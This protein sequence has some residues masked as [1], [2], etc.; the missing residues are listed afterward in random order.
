MEDDAS[1]RD[2]PCENRFYLNYR[3]SWRLFQPMRVISCTPYSVFENDPPGQHEQDDTPVLSDLGIST[4]P[5]D[6]GSQSIRYIEK[7]RV[8]LI[9]GNSAGVETTERAYAGKW[10]WRI[11]RIAPGFRA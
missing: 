2:G 7:T 1:S 3:I 4:S 9:H 5:L 10:Q 8:L 6:S 11:V